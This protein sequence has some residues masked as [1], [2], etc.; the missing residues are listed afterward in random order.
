MDMK[1]SFLLFVACL[2]FVLSSPAVAG[3]AHAFKLESRQEELMHQRSCVSSVLNDTENDWQDKERPDDKFWS[4]MRDKFNN[5]QD[6][7]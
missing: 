6:N 7:N 3:D 2:G 1:K 4:G 5:L